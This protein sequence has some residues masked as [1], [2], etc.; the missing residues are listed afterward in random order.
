MWFLVVNKFSCLI[1][2]STLYLT[3]GKLLYILNCRF[4][5]Q[6]W[7]LKMEKYR[8]HEKSLQ[9]YLKD[10]IRHFKPFFNPWYGKN[11]KNAYF[12][13]KKEANLTNKLI[14]LSLTGIKLSWSCNFGCFVF[15]EFY[16]LGYPSDCSS[17]DKN[18][19][20]H[21]FWYLKCC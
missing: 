16:P 10:K 6:V 18:R 20:E 11:N 5:G 2:V 13:L 3:S 1:I 9:A 19:S 7:E 12:S 15:F 14:L 21:R 17:Y 4:Q 8:K